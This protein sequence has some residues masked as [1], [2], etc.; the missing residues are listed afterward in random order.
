MKKVESVSVSCYN[1]NMDHNKRRTMER[2]CIKCKESKDVNEFGGRGNSSIFLQSY[3]KKCASLDKK[4]RIERE[5]W[6]ETFKNI[7]TRCENTKH[8]SYKKYGAKGIKNNIT[9][10]ELKE[11]WY[12]DNAGSMEKAS[13]DRIEHDEDYTFGNCRYIEYS[14]NSKKLH[15]R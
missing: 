2:I 14:E 11:L 7:R 5:P 1:I 6:K 10:E 3:C 4:A 8:T 13:I 15:L 12:R 9:I